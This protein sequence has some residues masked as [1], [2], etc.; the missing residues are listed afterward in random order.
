MNIALWVELTWVELWPGQFDR[1]PRSTLN[2]IM[3]R[4]QLSWILTW[5]DRPLPRSTLNRVVNRIK[6][7][8]E[9]VGLI[10]C[11]VHVDLWLFRGQ[12]MTFD[13]VDF[14]LCL[15]LLPQ[16]QTLVFLFC[17]HVGFA[18]TK[19]ERWPQ[20]WK[21]LLYIPPPPPTF[22]KVGGKIYSLFGSKRYRTIRSVQIR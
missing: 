12:T 18:G 16:F 2:W 5:P 3:N 4:I 20:R 17:H 14:N 6:L 22:C 1:L 13:L 10:F 7:K 8:F 21:F 11:L 15:T 9:L 19:K